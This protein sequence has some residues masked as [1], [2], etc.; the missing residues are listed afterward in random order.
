MGIEPI[1]YYYRQILSLLRLPFRHAS[2]K[3]VLVDREKGYLNFT[4]YVLLDLFCV[5]L[6]S[7]S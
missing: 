7:A 6:C 5:E 4:L 1:K 3:W 2:V